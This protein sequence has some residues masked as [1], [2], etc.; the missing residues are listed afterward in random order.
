MNS[1]EE[2]K[3][4][5]K[6]KYSQIAV[7]SDVISGCGCGCGE[8][9][10]AD[11]TTFD[12]DYKSQRGYLEDA[13]LKLGCGVPT[14]FAGIGKGDTVVDL[15]SGAGND[16]FVARALTGDSGRVIGIDFSED[17]LAKANKNKSKLNFENVEFR[18]G[19]IEEIP[20]ED[21]T[22]D[23]V[24]S[25]CV[26]NLV[27]DKQKACAEIMRILKPGGHFCISDIVLKGELP[28]ELQ[29]SAEAYA[30]CVSGALQEDEYIEIIRS[31][32]FDTIR[33][34]ASNEVILPDELLKEYLESDDLE[35]FNNK[36]FGIFSITVVGEKSE[37]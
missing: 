4:I 23:V 33:I 10:G 35:Q 2:I 27:P 19:E 21:N 18:I 25:N 1:P 30:G 31:I 5:V 12:L 7:E 15:G 13:D 28:A 9:K 34:E 24:I 37:S 14:E 16:V 11:Y 26:L 20:L 17:M 3:K 6:E 36:E 29:K 8:N 22:A 32:G